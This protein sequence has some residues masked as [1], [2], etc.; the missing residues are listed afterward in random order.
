MQSPIRS[1][2]SGS[3]IRTLLI[4]VQKVKVDVALAMDGYVK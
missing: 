1:A 4:Q 2:V 3:L